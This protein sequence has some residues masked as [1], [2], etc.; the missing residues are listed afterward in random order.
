MLQLDP[1]ER[2]SAADALKS[3]YL[4]PYH[5]PND[6]PVAASRFDWSMVDAN[7]PPDM[8]KTVM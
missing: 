6:E 4:A 8:W 7:L 2:I 1:D 3:E 5:D